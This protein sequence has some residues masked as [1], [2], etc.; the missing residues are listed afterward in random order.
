MIGL[1]LSPDRIWRTRDHREIRLG[2][3]KESHIR[4]AYRMIKRQGY[5]SAEHL[6]S[7]LVTA[8]PSGDMAQVAWA[9]EL[10]AMGPSTDWLD[11]F[12]AELKRRGLDTTNLDKDDA[13]AEST[14]DGDK[15]TT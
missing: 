3:M 4:N 2:D 15:E 5:T 7:M 6:L 10:D 11:A 1:D 14:A 13:V 9:A 12:V 8:P